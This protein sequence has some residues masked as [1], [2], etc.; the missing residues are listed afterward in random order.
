MRINSKLNIG[1]SISCEL[2][3]RVINDV[4]V[5]IRHRIV[6]KRNLANYTLHAKILIVDD[7]HINRD[8]GVNMLSSF[9]NLIVDTTNCY[10]DALY[11]IRNASYDLVFICMN[12]SDI[13]K[14]NIVHLIAHIRP[15][16][17]V[18]AVVTHTEMT[19]VNK[20]LRCGF[21]DV[22]CKPYSKIIMID[23]INRHM[24]TKV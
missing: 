4:D 7:D 14:I 8:I 2:T 23:T 5:A 12:T 19:N 17:K 11:K 22:L 16:I 3:L 20:Y 21:V 24:F 1:T 13:K 10:T 15:N 9:V 6:K 18:I